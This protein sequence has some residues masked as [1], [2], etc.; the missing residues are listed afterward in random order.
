MNTHSISVRQG[1]AAG[2]KT[3]KTL[4]AWADGADIAQATVI[5]NEENT[6]QVGSLSSRRTHVA[7]A[8]RTQLPRAAAIYLP[9]LP[10]TPLPTCILP[11]LL[12]PCPQVH[13]ELLTKALLQRMQDAGGSL[14]LAAVTAVQAAGG[15]VT[16]VTVRDSSSGEERQ[17]T[18]DAY[19]FAAGEAGWAL[20]GRRFGGISPGAC[21]AVAPRCSSHRPLALPAGAW[22]TKLQGAVPQLPM[23]SALKVHSIV[24]DDPQQKTTADALFLAYRWEWPCC[25]P[26]ARCGVTSPARASGGACTCAL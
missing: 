17:L 7:C 21:L 11:L 24:L 8:S 15:R 20:V 3:H 9:A 23:I 16:G 22:T 12:S 5:G 4:P 19:V 1:Q 18:A 6:A 25:G 10:P 2:V 14:Q 26:H 13:P